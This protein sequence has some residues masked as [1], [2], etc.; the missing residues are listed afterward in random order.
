MKT[1]VILVRHGRTDK[2]VSG[3]LHSFSDDSSLT[4]EGRGQMEK[5]A[6]WLKD[7]GVSKIYSSREERAVQSAEILAGNLRLTNEVVIGLEERN[8]G[9]F[10]GRP[11]ATVKEILDKFSL[12]ERYLYKSPKGESWQEFENRTQESLEGLIKQNLG[13]TLVVVTHGGVIRVLLPYLLGVKKEESFKYDP[14]NASLT[15]FEFIDGSF[16]PIV[17]DDIKHL[18]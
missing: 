18:S 12:E 16:L 1:T 3:L 6:S 4:E 9:E 11:W 17:I 10:E 5:T 15:I 7:L 13:K 14:K 2:N 8:W